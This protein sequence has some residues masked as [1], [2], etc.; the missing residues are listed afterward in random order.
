MGLIRTG[1][2]PTMVYGSRNLSQSTSNFFQARG[3]TGSLPLVNVAAN[4][5]SSVSADL[6]MNEIQVVA[7]LIHHIA[8]PLSAS[9]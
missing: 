9:S 6:K 5:W 3:M 4:A 1:E 8:H 7:R 2:Q